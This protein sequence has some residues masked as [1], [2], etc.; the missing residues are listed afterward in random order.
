MN[1]ELKYWYLRNHKLFWVLNNQDIKQLCI[2]TGFRHAKKGE[3]VYLS[4]SDEA[5]IY[6]LKKG[7][8]KIVKI[9]DD[10]NELIR[11]IILKGDLFGQLEFDGNA[12]NGEYAVAL[13]NDVTICSF[14]HDDFEKVLFKHPDLAVSY[15]KI[16]GFHLK[17]IRNNYANLMFRNA[18]ERLNLFLKEWYQKE[19]NEINRVIVL[20]NYLTQSDIAQIICTSRQTAT[21]LLNDMEH[22]GILKYERKQIQ[23]FKPE[24]L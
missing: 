12:E 1:N 4:S 7:S 21:Q 22:E 5:R 6:L 20:K 24:L 10:G 8:L 2:I 15:I 17:R 11:D 19:G 3:I 23:I 14:L 13:T 16:V 18:R 9:D